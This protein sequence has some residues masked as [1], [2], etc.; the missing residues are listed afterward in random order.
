MTL[1]GSTS[2]G[3]GWTTRILGTLLCLLVATIHFI[4]QGGFSMKHPTY[5]GIGFYILEVVG[6]ITAIL[7]LGGM[8]R[9]GWFL[10]V[11]VAAGPLTGYILSRGPGLPHY[12]E[13]VGNWAE[14]LG[15]ASLI[16]EGLLLVVSVAIVARLLTVRGE[17]LSTLSGKQ[18]SQL[19]WSKVVG[20]DGQHV[21][22]VWIP[23]V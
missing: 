15:V 4:D 11:G 13:D 20:L 6:V 2:G 23:R 9:L 3:L 21:G 16:V 14:P 7:L 19:R 17:K 12:T 8:T 1:N 10:A 22:T 18:S 5:V